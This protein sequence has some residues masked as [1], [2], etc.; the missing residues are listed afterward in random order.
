MDLKIN[1]DA[2][3]LENAFAPLTKQAAADM[4]ATQRLF[5]VCCALSIFNTVLTIVHLALM[6]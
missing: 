5:E 6:R 4:R 2:S 1:V 3:L